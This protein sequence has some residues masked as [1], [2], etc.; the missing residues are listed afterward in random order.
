L[1]RNSLYVRDRRLR[2]RR[3]LDTYKLRRGCDICGYREHPVA[4]HFDH[5]DRSQKRYAI[6]IMITHNLKRLFEEIRKCRVLCA[7]CHY[8]ETH[9]ERDNEDTDI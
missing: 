1:K 9:K 3:W 4:L 5:L 6:G 8:V 2:R 7:N